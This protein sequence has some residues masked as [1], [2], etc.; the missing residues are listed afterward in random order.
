VEA[1]RELTQNLLVSLVYHGLYADRTRVNRRVD[2]IPEQFWA[3]GQ[4]RNNELATNLNANV[5]NPFF[6]GNFSTLQQSHPLIYQS[7]TSSTW[8]TSRIIRKHELLR[9]Y[10]QMGNRTAQNDGVG[11][12]R[13]D[14]LEA[15]IQRRFAGGYTFSFSHQGLR[16]VERDFFYN[17]FDL[18]P[19]ERASNQGVPHR[20]VAMGI[21]RVALRSRQT[22]ASERCGRRAIRRLADRS[23]L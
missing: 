9:A 2:P 11:T 16:A 6:I 3:D 18:E 12:A 4:V 7:M 21:F 23:N 13:S 14:S 8:F 1:Q 10:P 20:Y 19:S 5:T 15:A 22:L 17:E